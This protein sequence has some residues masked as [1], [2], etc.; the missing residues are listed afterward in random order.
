MTAARL[1]AACLALALA[2]CA[3]LPLPPEHPPRAAP[4]AVMTKSKGPVVA[5][6]L[7][8]GGARGFAHI[9]A[10]K[11]LDQ[12][13][14]RPDFVV[15]TSAGS[16]IGALYA[17]G[18][19]D[20]ALVRAALSLQRE[21]VLDVVFPHRGFIEGE[22][23]QE[24]VNRELG[25]RLIEELETPFVVVVTELASGERVVFNRGDT[26]MAVRASC[27]VP[28]V[29]QPT[30]IEGREYVDGG[31]TSPVPVKVARQMGADV[32]IAIDVSRHPAERRDLGSTTALLTQTVLIME[33][34]LAREEEKLADVVVRPA[35][36]ALSATDLAARGEA[37]RAGE[38]AAR[39][40]LGAIRRAIAA[41]APT[42]R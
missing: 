12:A 8:G 29:F 25:G 5:L 42:P 24:Y 9:G 32:V 16:I 41:R 3:T 18:I 30:P 13:G 7:G 23:L 39:G 40:A 27:S 34:A 19:R 26:G 10:L 22:K 4:L 35:L 15:G 2:A 11:V 28:A 6:V 17:G 14:V 37:I 38:D 20:D 33:R 36:E 31:L 21:E 1:A